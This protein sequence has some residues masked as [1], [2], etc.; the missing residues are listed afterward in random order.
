MNIRHEPAECYA[1]CDDPQCPYIHTEAWFVKAE[2]D[3]IE[4]GPFHTREEA[5][6]C[7]KA[8]LLPDPDDQE[9]AGAD[10]TNDHCAAHS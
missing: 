4:Y 7:N 5:V 3:G 9:I 1:G 2:D 6:A 8:H 10:C